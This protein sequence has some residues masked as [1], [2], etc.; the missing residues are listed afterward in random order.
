MQSALDTEGEL[1]L[2]SF[3]FGPLLYENGQKTFSFGGLPADSPVSGSATNSGS[4]PPL[5]ITYVYICCHNT[6]H[7]GCQ[8]VLTA[9]NVTCAIFYI[10]DAMHVV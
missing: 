1:S 5:F 9:D 7:R 3:T 10:L 6:F 4:V 2:K 8:F